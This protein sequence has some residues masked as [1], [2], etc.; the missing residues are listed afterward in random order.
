MDNFVYDIPTTIYFGKNQIQLLGDV[1]HRYGTR[2][3][4]V[5]GGGSIKKNGIYEQA[6]KI[7]GSAE[8]KFW[9]LAG[10]EPN[11]GIET[12]RRGVQICRENDIQ[13]IVPVGGGSVIDCGKVVAAGACYAGDAW[14]LV[15]D[16]GK[17]QQALPIIPVLTLAATG[18]EMDSDAVISDTGRNRKQGTSSPWMLPKVSF[19]DPTYTESVNA[20]QTACG[21]ADIMSHTLENYF[22][23]Q[24]A[25]LQE[26]LAEAILKT[27]I[28][29]GPK[30]ISDPHDYEAR[31]NLLW[32]GSWACN[33]FLKLGKSVRFS[34]HAIE[35]QLSAHYG[36]T[37]GAGMA[38]LTPHWMRYVLD[39][40]SVQRFREY[41]I[42]VWGISEQLEP[43]AAAKEAIRQTAE[44]LKSLGLPGTLT[45]AGIGDEKFSI[46]AEAAAA[47]MKGT[48][49]DLSKEQI[50]DLYRKA[51]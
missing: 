25:Y 19:M 36:I 28:E 44:F 30:A 33:G 12:V 48:Y 5:Y 24:R 40:T 2:A 42:N 27:C 34:V 7:F 6:A 20:W 29:F 50:E 16:G 37:H 39:D 43:F 15:E 51:L 1:V 11:P 45:E 41:G 35:H 47:R 23:N 17:I 8:I 22:S 9:E 14:E 18:S 31:A 26:R 4:L 13:V 49:R 46:M 3:L 21:T 10:V 38:I 32:A